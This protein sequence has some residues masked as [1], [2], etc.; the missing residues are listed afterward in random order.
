[1]NLFIYHSVVATQEAKFNFKKKNGE[2]FISI[3]YGAMELFS[4]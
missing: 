2:V 3:L 1:V 4:A